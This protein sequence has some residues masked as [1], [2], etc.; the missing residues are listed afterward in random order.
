M[1]FREQEVLMAAEK[2][3]LEAFLMSEYV[4]FPVRGAHKK[5]YVPEHRF[6]DIFKLYCDDNRY[7]F[8]RPQQSESHQ[9]LRQYNI[10]IAKSR[11]KA[12]P[13]CYKMYPRPLKMPNRTRENESHK[14]SWFKNI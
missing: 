8:F 7:R 3:P 1:Y 5:V 10:E 4:V 2:N 13:Q 11:T 14:V 9:T 12:T 6:F